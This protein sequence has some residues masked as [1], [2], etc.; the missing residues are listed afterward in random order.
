MDKYEE[1]ASQIIDE[2]SEIVEKQHP[3]LNLNSET[4]KKDGIDNPAV[5]VG[6]DYYNLEQSIANEIKDFV[7][8]RKI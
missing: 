6:V 7:K 3:E 1:L 2:V 4:A 5:I 8:N